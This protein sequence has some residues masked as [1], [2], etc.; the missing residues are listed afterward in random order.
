MNYSL[1]GE[2]LHVHLQFSVL[3]GYEAD[4]ACIQISLTDI[5]A[6]KKAEAYLEFLGKHDSLTRLRNRSF[7][8]DELN[9]LEREAIHPL[10]VL[11]IDLNGLKVA[12]D[13]RGH[14]V[15]DAL[16]RRAG[17]VLNK[18]VEAPACAAR[19]GGDEFIVLL[20]GATE[21]DAAQMVENIE[22]LLAL[23][24][25]FYPGL[26]LSMSIGCATAMAPQRLEDLVQLADARMYSTKAMFY[27]DA[28]S[29]IHP[30]PARLLNTGL[31]SLAHEPQ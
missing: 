13:T 15:G 1:S 10:S 29:A 23:N 8:T 11:M 6:R 22:Q 30:A 27:G 21:A 12:N 3:P 4:W 31:P 20:P 19:I 14:I 9:R 7:F 5:S 17:E 25:Q 18:A 26:A 16:L 24:N 2:R 28:Q